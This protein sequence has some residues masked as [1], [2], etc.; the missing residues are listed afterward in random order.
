MSAKHRSWPSGVH[1]AVNARSAIVAATNRK[2]SADAV[3][4]RGTFRATP[5]YSST[6]LAEL[7]SLLFTGEG[8]SCCEDANDRGEASTA[9]CRCSLNDVHSAK[10][11]LTRRL[12]FKAVL[13]YARLTPYRS[14]KA[15]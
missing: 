14:A 13:I 3:I 2:H 5:P 6:L 4:H 12:P 11:P 10:Q 8:S 1:A 7:R 15:I 9:V